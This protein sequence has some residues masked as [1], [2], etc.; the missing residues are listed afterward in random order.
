MPEHWD[1]DRLERVTKIIDAGLNVKD[2]LSQALNKIFGA[3]YDKNFVS[4]IKNTAINQ[5]I[6]N[7]Q[8]IIQQLL[9]DVDRK[10]ARILRKEAL[11]Q[12]KTEAKTIYGALMRKYQN[13]LPLFK[14]LAKG[15]RVLLAVDKVKN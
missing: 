10:Q 12:L 11:E 9:L 3:G 1:N 7:A 13:D 2:R 14:A 8:N 5:Y 15:E 6:S 4:G